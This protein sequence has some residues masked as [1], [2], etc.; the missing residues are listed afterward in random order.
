MSVIDLRSDTLTKPTEA[1]LER[2]RGAELGDD[3]RDGDPTVLALEALAAEHTGKEAGLFVVSGTMGNLVAQLT[4]PQAAAEA[5][6]Q[7]NRLH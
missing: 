7:E 4:H 1:M 3:S 6:S 2:M 5:L